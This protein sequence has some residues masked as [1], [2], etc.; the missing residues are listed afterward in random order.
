M[1][2]HKEFTKKKINEHNIDYLINHIAE[3]CVNGD[4]ESFLKTEIDFIATKKKENV[5]DGF[6]MQY[7]NHWE[8]VVLGYCKKNKIKIA[9][10]TNPKKQ[11]VKEQTPNIID[12]KKR[13][14]IDNVFDRL[15]KKSLIECN[16]NEFNRLFNGSNINTINI[17]WSGSI[18][19]LKGLFSELSRIIGFNN[20]YY[21]VTC[22]GVEIKQIR[23]NK[24]SKKDENTI[25][26][27]LK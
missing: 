12:N 18:G 11:A 3:N 26:E 15:G 6:A 8:K 22:F 24:P 5:T 10:E 17:K 9:G 7:F 25:K 23:N 2:W 4:I 13:D 16:K 19:L 1:G 20:K 21:Y 27:L 14:I